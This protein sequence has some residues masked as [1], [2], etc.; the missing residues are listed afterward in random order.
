MQEKVHLSSNGYRL[1]SFSLYSEGE[2]SD[3][4]YRGTAI[5]MVSNMNYLTL[6]LLF[7]SHLFL[8]L[9]VSSGEQLNRKLKNKKK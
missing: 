5:R 7:K 1:L 2:G 3:H 6:H 9:W 8:H 4:M